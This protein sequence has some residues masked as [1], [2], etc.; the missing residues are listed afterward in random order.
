[1]KAL[2][3]LFIASAGITSLS[4]GQGLLPGKI[5]GDLMTNMNFFSRDSSIKA[6]DNPLYDNLLS[7][8]EAWLGLRYSQE[9]FD[10][11][12]RMDVFNNS[13][14][15]VPTQPTTGFGIGAWGI[16][17]DIQKLNITGGYIYDQIGSGSIFR[18]Y[19]DR[20]LLIDNALVGLRLKYQL[21]DNISVKAFTGQQKFL[22]ERYQPIIKGLSMDGN[23]NFKNK[24]FLNPGF[25]VVNRTLDKTSIDAV[26]T[27]TNALPLEQ[28]K[29][30]KYN[31]YAGSVYNTL[32]I[33]GF[34]WYVEGALKSEEAFNDY[35]GNLEYNSGSFLYSTLSYAMEGLAI[36]VTGK[37]TQNFVMRTSP[38]ENANLGMV[39]WQPL[40]AQIRPQRLIARYM[41]QSLDWSE[42]ALNG[43]VMYVPNDNYDF[44]VSYTHINK[45][46]NEKLYREAYFETNIRSLRDIR[47]TLGLHYMEYNQ[48]YY[49]FKPG[50]SMVKA[51]TPFA[52]FVYK[53]SPKQSISVQAQ[54][55]DTKQDFGSWAFLQLEYAIAPMWSF[56]V[57]DMYNVKPAHTEQKAE[58]Y[59]NFFIA[60]TRGANRFSAAWVKQ[61]EGINC[62]GGVCRYEPAFNGL[63]VMVTSTF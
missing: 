31:M 26:V 20:G 52:E 49:Q 28:R 3:L 7:G 50:V 2:S 60:H 32:S 35:K 39:G 53:L 4:Y 18:S 15:L 63:R 21:S 48:E 23:F 51:I 19:E 46:D 10:A 34:S 16:S 22:F 47:L 36:N 13:N 57:S 6:S 58:H 11:F 42:M 12:V 1:M 40:V 30:A 14:L 54:Y 37:R 62:T 61:V 41:P 33:G 9:G 43:N 5:S 27:R 24:V 56:A 29:E 25:G 59:Y 55:M 45:L 17:K 38:S 8:G 44:N